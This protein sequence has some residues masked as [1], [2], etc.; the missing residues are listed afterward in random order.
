MNISK[1]DKNV[2]I[3]V[4]IFVVSIITWIQISMYWSKTTCAKIVSIKYARGTYVNIQFVKNGEIVGD[5]VEIAYF[6]YKNLKD[7]QKKECCEI[8]YS[9]YWPYNIQIID[10]E[11]K[12]R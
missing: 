12:A 2:L 6:R 1:R 9:I 4:V 8:K 10:E 7:L 11:L 5:R 3:I